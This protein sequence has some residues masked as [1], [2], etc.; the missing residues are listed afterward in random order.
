MD[1]SAP[2]APHI[3]AA[4]GS[5]DHFWSLLSFGY[6][7]A[8]QKRGKLTVLVVSADGKPPEW[9]I[10]PTAYNQLDIEIVVEKGDEVAS[11]VVG[12][13]QKHRPDLLLV[14]WRKTP[15]SDRYRLRGTLDSILR[16]A[17]CDIAVVRADPTFPETSLDKHPPLSILIPAAGG[18]N[19]PLAME[20]ALALSPNATVTA[21]RVAP[22]H[23]DT[24]D[25]LEHQQQLAQMTRQWADNPRLHAKTIRA[26]SVMKGI[27]EEAAA[28]D[29]TMLGATAEGLFEQIIFGV[30]PE[31]IGLKNPHTTVIVKRFDGSF[32][33]TLERWWWRMMHA[34]PVLSTAE[35]AE[36]YKQIRRGARPETDFFVMI[37]L[38]SAIAALGLLLNSPA[39]IIGAM[40]VAPLMSAIMG[41]GLGSI[42]ADVRLLELAG[43]ATLR[44]M[45]L[46]IAVGAAAKLIVPGNGAPTAE[47]LARTAPSLLDLGVAIF[48]GLAG[49]YALSRKNMSSSL[50]GVAIAAALVPPLATVGIGVAW[51]RWD[52][53]GGAL[54][55]FLTNLVAI[56][57]ASGFIFFLLGFRPQRRKRRTRI[58]RRAVVSSAI[59]LA[60]MAW[61]LGSLT[62]QSYRE[63]AQKRE[64][65]TALRREVSAMA[66]NIALEDWRSVEKNADGVRLEISVRAPIIPTHQNAVDLQE[67]LT[68]DLGYPVALT[69][70]SVRTTT[71]DPLLPPTP[72]ATVPPDSSPTPTPAATKTPSPTLTATPSPAPTAT[73]SPTA[74]VTPTPTATV[75]PSPTATATPPPTPTATPASAVIAHTGGRGVVLRWNPGGLRAGALPENTVVTVLYRRETA[76][77]IEWVEV[78]D[79]AGRRGWVAADYLEYLFS[80]TEIH[81][82]NTKMHREK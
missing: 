9:L 19:A 71:L 7:L 2:P 32:G 3:V 59:L 4:I 17:P 39:V 64:I 45:L 74:T 60:L 16:Q 26:E 53:A 42:Q 82:E 52:V 81:K 44:G 15:G 61:I 38:A 28:Y 79:S 50:P 55:L 76:N 22:E 69:L 80:Y 14:A 11:H 35:R 68:A 78:R 13:A 65:D 54:L 56:V 66:K 37:G 72:T 27:L 51:L 12:Y 63:N 24:A 34:L 5:Q 58:F 43:S 30:L 49:A 75:T 21:L 25:F 48:S 67:A 8:A 40:L 18:P 36:V 1:T 73:P 20:L 41:M 57:A 46:A 31:K 10:I 33:G 6:A 47:I 77:G 29:I 70:I 62:L 23:T